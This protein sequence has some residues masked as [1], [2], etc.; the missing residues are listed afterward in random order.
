MDAPI[1]LNHRIGIIDLGSNSARLMVAHYAPGQAFRITDEISRRVRLSEG[2]AEG[3]GYLQPPAIAR[4]LETIQMFHDFC[5]ANSIK[6]VWPVATA[7]V[8][9]AV[10]QQ[11]FLAK[12]EKATGLKFRVLTGEEEAYFGAVGAIN[13][14]GL[15]DGL[16]LDV[17]GGSAEVSEVHNGTFKRGLTVPLVP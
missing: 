8:R 16:V 3:G 10:N 2:M 7:A 9:D 13:S 12:V 14:V 5:I 15:R 11:E 1:P 17:G 6:Q 4:A